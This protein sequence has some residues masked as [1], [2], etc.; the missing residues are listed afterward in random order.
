MVLPLFTIVPTAKSSTSCEKRCQ[1][2]KASPAVL[3]A[4]REE[5]VRG[6]DPG[7][8]VRVLGDE[9]EA[10]EPA[11]VLAHEGDVA[12]VELRRARTRIQ[13]TWRW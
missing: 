6:D 12:E 7:E 2:R 8:A 1:A 10:D 3:V 13:S 11:P 4:G 9:A 5:R